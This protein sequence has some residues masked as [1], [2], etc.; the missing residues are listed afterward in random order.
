MKST[1]QLEL[2]PGAHQ[3]WDA[4]NRFQNHQHTDDSMGELQ[5]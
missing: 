4:N 2:Q 1:G 5:K 3:V